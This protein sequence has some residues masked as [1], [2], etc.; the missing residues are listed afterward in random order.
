MPGRHITDAQTRL[1]LNYQKT[2]TVKTAAAKAGFRHGFTEA[3]PGCPEIRI[4]MGWGMVSFHDAIPM[5]A[6]VLSFACRSEGADPGPVSVHLN[7]RPNNQKT[8]KL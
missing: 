5:S 2:D 6:T 3:C 1:L 8:P 4:V 7:A